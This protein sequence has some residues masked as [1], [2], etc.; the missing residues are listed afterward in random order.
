M[1]GCGDSVKRAVSLLI[2]A[3]SATPLFAQTPEDEPRYLSQYFTDELHPR[4]ETD[5]SVFYRAVQATEDI[6]AEVADYELSFAA[7]S[8]RG[9]R[10]DRHAALLNG[11]PLR[12]EYVT[13]LDRL[14]FSRSR[15]SGMRHS[16]TA[17]G[18]TAGFTEYRTDFSEPLGARS[19]N[20]NFAD[21]GYMFGLRASAAE[22]LRK[23]WSLAAYLSG[24]TGRDLHADGVF[25]NALDAG[26][27]LSKQWNYRCGLTVA[28]LFSPSERGVRRSSTAE[29]FTLTGDNLY[30]PSWGYQKGKVRNANVRRTLVPTVAAA[31]DAEITDNTK[32]TVTAAVEAG[33]VKYSSLEW[34]DA[35]TPIPDNYRYMPSYFDNP[36]IAAVVADVWRDRNS[37]YTQIDWDELY[38]QNRLAGG[39]SVYAVSD[40]AERI[41]DLALHAAGITAVGEKITVGYGVRLSYDRR[42][43]YRQMRDLLGGSHIIDIDQY[44]ADDAAY[45]N[46]LQN[47]LRHP[48][49][50]IREGDRFGYDYAA[51]RR[52]AGADVT[53]SRRSDRTRLDIAAEIGDM[54]IFRRGFY[55]KEL[56]AGSGSY[57]RSRKIR[58]APYTLKAAF[59]Y[60]FTPRHYLELCAVAS[61]EAP[62]AEDLFLQTQYNNRTVDN[63]RLQRSLGAE[64][65][66]TFLHR[67]INLR[68]TLFATS[69][70][71]GCEVSHYYD[72]LASEYS[73]MVVSGID[74][75]NLGLELAATLY[76]SR[77]WRASAAFTAGRYVYSS[78]PRVTLY[79]DTDNRL[80][81]DHAVAHMGGVHTGSAPHI[82]ATAEVTYMNRGW[83]IRLGANCA[84]MRYVEAAPMRR[85][86]RVSRQGS[87]SEE[88]FR[89]FVEQERLPD[90]FTVDAAVW[91]SFRLTRDFRSSQR[92]V[93]SVSAR[94]LVGSRDII[95]SG[96]EQVR[97]RR[98][99]IAGSYLYDPFPTRYLYAY[100]RTFRLSV[101]YRF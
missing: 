70:R 18:G 33:V 90:A 4:I 45:S 38:E 75:L 2:A 6:F 93:V 7:F 11:I 59:G 55:E 73:D 87:V 95:Y 63:P 98:T 69:L 82:A 31:F 17:L 28:A 61:G 57:G 22:T 42:R 54:T 47:D 46:M 30:N 96:Y 79:A 27:K 64:L 49:R 25:T 21:R 9:E 20:I 12:P 85:T 101:T 81:C 39:H 56:F 68:A 14:Q 97:I 15:Y 44:L 34:F 10:F 5:S 71:N 83:G 51:V 89:R 40:R 91:K 74:K 86:D 77:N 24:R 62:D 78:D 76:I 43:H 19:V 36:D 94:N 67:T 72:D 23:G 92:L 16:E 80:L 41:T 32:L 53:F 26:L 50:V 65:N 48:D 3:V 8:R 29:A 99:R 52:Y 35:L 84:A 13:T 37:R 88:T 58:M 60:S 66:Y 1:L 100:P